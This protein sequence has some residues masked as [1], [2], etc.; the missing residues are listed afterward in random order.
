[1]VV[2]IKPRRGQSDR[3]K[4]GPHIDRVRAVQ[5]IKRGLADVKAGRTTPAREVFA[6]LTH[7]SFAA[8]EGG[9]DFFSS[10]SATIGSRV[11][12]E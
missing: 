3:L 2:E 12:S 6:G 9:L 11:S 4:A 7:R 8:R 5:G 1:M 10:A